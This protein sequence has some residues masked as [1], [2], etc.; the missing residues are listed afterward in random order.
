MNVYE[1]RNIAEQVLKNKEDIL[2]HFQ[3]D[4]VLADFGIRIIGQVQTPEELPASASEYGDAYAVG[5]QSPF[6]YYIWTRANNLSPVDYWFNFGEIAIAGPQGPVGPQGIPGRDGKTNKWY[7][8]TGDTVPAGEN[9]GDLALDD[10]GN[11]YRLINPYYDWSYVMNIKGPQGPQGQ[12]GDTGPRGAQGPQGPKGEQGDVGG[13]INIAAIV[14]GDDLLPDPEVI[15]DLTVA[16]LVGSDAPYDLWIQ[17]GPSSATAQWFNAGPLNVATMVTSGGVYLNTW[18]ADTKLDKIPNGATPMVYA[19]NETGSY[20]VSG[21]GYVGYIPL[22]TNNSSGQPVLNSKGAPTS[23]THLA[24]KAYVD[25]KVADAASRGS[26]VVLN[27]SLST[28]SQEALL[29]IKKVAEHYYAD[30]GLSKEFIFALRPS[31]TSK[32]LY[33][34]EYTA[35]T[36]TNG[37]FISLQYLMANTDTGSLKVQ[38]TVNADG[39][40]TDYTIVKT[41]IA[42]TYLPADLRNP[43]KF[44]MIDKM[45]T[46]NGVIDQNEYPALIAMVNAIRL[47]GPV[48]AQGTGLPAPGLYF[49]NGNIFTT[50]NVEYSDTLDY[51]EKVT[52]GYYDPITKSGYFWKI[53]Y[54]W[55]TYTLEAYQGPNEILF[56]IN[57]G[58]YNAID[59]MTWGEWIRSSYNTLGLTA[60]TTLGDDT[61]HVYLAYT[62]L[63]LYGSTVST[64]DPVYADS[65]YEARI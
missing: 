35:S 9:N 1:K 12:K 47:P 28:L 45:P 7:Y 14:S 60:G 50:Q 31:L 20:A 41:R 65:Y 18:D 3:R 64:T 44:T 63:T 36:R 16:Y 61:S 39:G 40:V 23:N 2:K 48:E 57:D 13:F 54:T 25:S 49:Y 33:P 19:T 26:V 62:P 58:D 46:S 6:N 43:L 4:E 10:N 29:A 17:V 8:F 22:W 59:G 51:N 32:L 5:T 30:G 34:V 27:P 37:M 11:I 55:G 24:N 21:S 56:Y 53:N 42:D 38:I 15:G 52:V